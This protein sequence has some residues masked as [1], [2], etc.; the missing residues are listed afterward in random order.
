MNKPTRKAI[1][2]SIRKWQRIYE[3]LKPKKRITTKVLSKLE[4]YDRGSANCPLC[5]M[6]HPYYSD[7][8]LCKGCPVSSKVH[9]WGCGSTPYYIFALTVVEMKEGEFRHYYN[10]T[11]KD[12]K[13]YAK[14]ELEFLKSLRE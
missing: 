9:D 2:G 4:E 10:H 6:Y 8:R 14:A 13:E 1:E 12:L 5:K 7:K 3:F 11:I